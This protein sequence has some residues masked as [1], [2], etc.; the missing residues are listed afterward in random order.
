MA[1][2]E[3]IESLIPRVEGLAESLNTP[4]PEGEVKEIERRQ[5]LREY[6]IRYQSQHSIPDVAFLG[7][8]RG[9]SEI[10]DRW[11]NV[12]KSPVYSTTSRM[13]RR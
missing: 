5:K 3:S 1:N 7:N 10:W 13:R 2:H 11:Q 9:H 6:I 8:W 4:A 12:A